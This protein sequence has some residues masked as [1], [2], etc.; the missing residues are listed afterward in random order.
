MRAQ[1][2][3]ALYRKELRILTSSW[4]LYVFFALFFFFTGWF[5]YQGILSYSAWSIQAPPGTVVN[6]QQHLFVPLYSN[7]MF[8]LTLLLPILTMR[9]VAE[10]RR[11]GTYSLLVTYPGSPLALLGAKY[12]SALTVFLGG[13]LFSGLYPIITSLWGGVEWP[14]VCT[15]YL[16]VALCGSAIL[17]MGLFFSTV[18]EHYLVAALLTEAASLFFW[19]IGWIANYLPD[20]MTRLVFGVSFY[21]RLKPF[22]LG[23]VDTDDTLYFLNV[24]GVF[25]FLGYYWIY[26][27]QQS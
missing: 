13:L 23:I 21:H 19:L 27:E 6:V 26:R 8:F 2:I 14:L 15:T 25:F 12:L 10:E 11:Q 18:A 5:Y 4:I 22:L 3:R 7:M 9:L 17:S 1:F 20:R 16:G 24:I